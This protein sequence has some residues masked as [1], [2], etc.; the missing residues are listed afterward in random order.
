MTN[1]PINLT[2][3]VAKKKND[4]KDAARFIAQA[5]RL[6]ERFEKYYRHESSS[7]YPLTASA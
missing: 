5:D 4:P 1:D 3:H 6:Q 2:E 7:A